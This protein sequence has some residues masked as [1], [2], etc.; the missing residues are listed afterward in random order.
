[1]NLHKN[2][3]ELLLKKPTKSTCNYKVHGIFNKS[4]NTVHV[5]LQIWHQLKNG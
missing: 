3:K 2:N 1:M 5:L 4:K